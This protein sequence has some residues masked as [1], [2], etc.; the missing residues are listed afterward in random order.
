MSLGDTGI[1][2]VFKEIRSL[3]QGVRPSDLE[4]S[5][6]GSSPARQREIPPPSN[7]VS[8]SHSWNKLC[9]ASS[10]IAQTCKPLAFPETLGHMIHPETLSKPQKTWS[11][12]GRALPSVVN[13]PLLPSPLPTS[14]FLTLSCTLSAWGTFQSPSCLTTNLTLWGHTSGC[15]HQ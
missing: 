1:L 4:V 14:H 8:T 13:S 6:P 2:A 12:H 15:P 7:A 11:L 5:E 9:L 3:T 10:Q